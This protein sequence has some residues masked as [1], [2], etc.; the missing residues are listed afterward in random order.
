M[1]SNC[2][3]VDARIKGCLPLATTENLLRTLAWNR[4]PD[5]SIGIKG[6]IASFMSTGWP[7]E[8]CE[9]ART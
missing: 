4:T 6:L 3:D 1:G 5:S 9:G 7:E 8:I 2:T